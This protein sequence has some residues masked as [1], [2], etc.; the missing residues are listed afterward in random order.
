MIGI[1]IRGEDQDDGKID[2]VKKN[3]KKQDKDRFH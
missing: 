3:K 1:K 2:E